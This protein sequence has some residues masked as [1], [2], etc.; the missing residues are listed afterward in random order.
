V[1][2]GTRARDLLP[3]I[4]YDILPDGRLDLPDDVLAEVDSVQASVHGGQGMPR[5]E[6]T[7][8][9]EEALRIPTCAVSATR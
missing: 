8:R 4:E 7:R 3:G 2:Q 6:P 5:R 9:V 1:S